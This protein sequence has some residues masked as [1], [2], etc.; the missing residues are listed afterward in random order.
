MECLLSFL[1][2]C[3][4]SDTSSFLYADLD[5]ADEVVRAPWMNIVFPRAGCCVCGAFS[6]NVA[7]LLQLR[8]RK[9]QSFDNHPDEQIAFKFYVGLVPSPHN[10]DPVIPPGVGY[11]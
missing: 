4:H 3:T 11:T 5:L 1:A 2:G 8:G 6:A 9:R 10:I 7:E